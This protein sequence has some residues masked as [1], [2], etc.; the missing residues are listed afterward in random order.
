MMTESTLERALRIRLEKAG[1]GGY[2]REHRFDTVRKWR[3]DFAWPP[4]KL[5]V[6]CEGGV[7][8]GGRHTSAQGFTGD[9]EKYNAAA[10]AGWT[11]L[12]FTADQIRSGYALK[13]IRKALLKSS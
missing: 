3:L 10:I 5:A 9:C 7:M 6:E 11:V 1:I 13:T 8:A 12:R 2:E 4:L